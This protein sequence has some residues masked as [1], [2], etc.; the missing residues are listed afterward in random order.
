[1]CNAQILLEGNHAG[2]PVGLGVPHGRKVFPLRT[3]GKNKG[4]KSENQ[5]IRRN[6]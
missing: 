3:S 1:M 2:H 5:G 6:S 4:E